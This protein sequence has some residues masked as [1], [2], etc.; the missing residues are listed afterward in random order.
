MGEKKDCLHSSVNY[1]EKKAYKTEMMGRKVR[2]SHLSLLMWI[3]TGGSARQSYYNKCSLMI[4]MA[5]L[6]V[7]GIQGKLF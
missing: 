2:Q 3:P 1:K 5:L 6:S 7:P 4:L